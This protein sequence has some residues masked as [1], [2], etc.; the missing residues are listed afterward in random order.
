MGRPLGSK[1]KPRDVDEQEI[2]ANANGIEGLLEAG[3][4]GVVEVKEEVIPEPVKEVQEVVK[5]KVEPVKTKTEEEIAIEESRKVLE[6]PLPPGQKFFEAPNGFI[7]VGEAGMG[8][9]LY[10]A[11][12]NGKGMY[13]NPKR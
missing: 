4:Q 11:G 12:N 13:I 9:I 10:R 5:A 7:M 3:S 2:V 6:H 1:N 8:R